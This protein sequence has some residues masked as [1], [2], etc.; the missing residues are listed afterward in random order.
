[1][2]PQVQQV[3][4][5]ATSVAQNA[6]KVAGLTAYDPTKPYS[7]VPKLDVSKADSSLLEGPRTSIDIQQLLKDNKEL[8]TRY[9]GTLTPSAEEKT[10]QDEL[11]AIKKQNQDAQMHPEAAGTPMS[12]VTASRSELAKEGA[13]KESNKLTELQLAQNRRTSEGEGLAKAIAFTTENF[14]TLSQLQK[15]TKPDVLGTKVNDQTGDVYSYIQD[16]QT[17][18]LT[19]K[20]IGN[21][22]AGKQFQNTGTYTN[23]KGQEVFYG[24]TPDGKIEQSVLGSAKGTGAT[25]PK[26]TDAQQKE[27]IYAVRLTDSNTVLNALSKPIATMNT[28]WFKA[29]QALPVAL[30]SAQF[31]QYDQAARNFING[32]LRPESGAAI[33]ESEFQNARSQYLPLPGDTPGTIALKER[34]RQV[35]IQG[36]KQ[37][38]GGAFSTL[39][40]NTPS[41]TPKVTQGQTSSGMKY[42]IIND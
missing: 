22:G 10:L 21:V 3:Q 24:V 13:L 7:A 11:L 34:N 25:T 30:Q 2:P 8:Q 42:Q 9:L 37:A 41:A 40:V 39:S 26:P 38:A 14:N 5:T 4:D 23:S 28:L 33:S 20:M 19:T 16:P 29:Q 35:V 31:Q 27:A 12:V 15:L 36:M 17:G 32:V 6:A 18:A 1:M